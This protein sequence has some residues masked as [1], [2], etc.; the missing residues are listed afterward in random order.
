MI[1]ATELWCTSVGCVRVESD[2]VVVLGEEVVK[3]GDR[4]RGAGGYT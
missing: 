2:E 1:V 4:I 3:W